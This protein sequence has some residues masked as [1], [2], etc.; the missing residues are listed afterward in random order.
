MEATAVGTIP[1]C[2]LSLTETAATTI[3]PANFTSDSR[4][5]LGHPLYQT[6]SYSIPGSALAFISKSLLSRCIF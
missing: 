5:Y 6:G 1:Q 2:Y 3:S 4:S